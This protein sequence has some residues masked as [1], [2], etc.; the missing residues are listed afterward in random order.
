MVEAGNG[1]VEPCAPYLSHDHGAISRSIPHNPL[2]GP[3]MSSTCRAS[4]E[5]GFSQAMMQSITQ[6]PARSV[7]RIS[8]NGLG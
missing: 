7:S 3:T 8:N 4:N 1:S 6:P 5:G 2:L